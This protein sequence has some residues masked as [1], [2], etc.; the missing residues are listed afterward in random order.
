MTR[1]A[2]GIMRR[3]LVRDSDRSPQRLHHR[4]RPRRSRPAITTQARGGRAQ[5]LDSLRKRLYAVTAGPSP[6][7]TVDGETLDRFRF[8]ERSAAPRIGARRK[9][10]LSWSGVAQREP[11]QSAG[12]PLSPADRREV[13]QRGSAPSSGRA[14][15]SVGSAPRFAGALAARVLE[16]W[17][18]VN[19][20]SLFEPGLVLPTGLT[21]RRLS[22]DLAEAADFPEP[23]VYQ[24]LGAD[25]GA[26][27]VRTIW[28]L[29]QG[30]LQ[31]PT[32]PSEGGLDSSW[33]LAGCEPQVSPLPQR[34]LGQP[35]ELLHETGHAVHISAIRSRPAS[36]T[37]PT[38]IRLPSSADFIALDYTSRLG[39]SI[40]WETRCPWATGSGAGTGGS[41]RRG[42]GPSSKPECSGSG[43]GPEPGCGPPSPT[44]TAQSP[45]PRALL[46][47]HARAG[48]DRL[49]EDYAAGSILIAAIRPE[50]GSAR[51]FVAEI[52]AGT[53]GWHRAST[54]L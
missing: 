49:P 43:C 2:V 33:N 46:V 15:T 3:T 34:R 38:A 8:W 17:R 18:D 54:A 48:D 24:S 29:T 32:A 45:S 35:H 25:L 30:R 47:G 14:G 40:G 20:Y 22:P 41:C 50:P 26:L 4:S 9:L 51:T 23:E 21:S 5:R 28:S 27:G 39:S 11:G 36:V 10:F 52:L 19:P 31:L 42:L 7:L 44:T 6:H 1:R 53:R 16:L 37:G 12:E 13:K